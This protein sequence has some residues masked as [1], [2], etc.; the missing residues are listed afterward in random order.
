MLGGKG[1]DNAVYF[2]RRLVRYGNCGFC[3][4]MI[5]PWGRSRE[6]E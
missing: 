5:M 3:W 6:L 4:A 1:S 2:L